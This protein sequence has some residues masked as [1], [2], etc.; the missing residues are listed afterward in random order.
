MRPHHATTIHQ[1]QAKSGVKRTWEP[2]PST[3]SPGSDPFSPTLLSCP[4]L[5]R[6]FLDPPRHVPCSPSARSKPCLA[7]LSHAISD[8]DHDDVEIV[9]CG[10]ENERRCGH[11]E[12]CWMRKHVKMSKQN[13]S[14]IMM[15]LRHLKRKPFNLLPLDDKVFRLKIS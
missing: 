9:W 4:V 13:E 10:G 6:V 1:Y 3:P 8:D 5:W 14:E 7:G 12:Y 15:L 2:T 11:N